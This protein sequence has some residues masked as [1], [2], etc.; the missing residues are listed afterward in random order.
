MWRMDL[1]ATQIVITNKPIHLSR[2]DGQEACLASRHGS[3]YS[4]TIL[5]ST[6]STE[7]YPVA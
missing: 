7:P 4:T 6:T 3:R 5:E 1:A 2:V